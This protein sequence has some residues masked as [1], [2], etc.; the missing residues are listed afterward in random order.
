MTSRKYVGENDYGNLVAR[1]K[2]T[3]ALQVGG[4]AGSYPSTL[5]RLHGYRNASKIFN[6]FRG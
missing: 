6:L 1:E 2:K 4:W 3:L 5:V